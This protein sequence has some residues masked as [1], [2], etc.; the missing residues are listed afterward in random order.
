MGIKSDLRIIYWGASE[1]S[2]RI[3]ENL[4]QSG[5]NIIGVVT[6]KDRPKGRGRKL[7]SMPVKE[8]ALKF[9]IHPVEIEVIT[10]DILPQLIPLKPQLGVIMGFGILPRNL[11]EFPD[12][13]TINLHPSL[14]PQLRGAAPLRWALINGLETSGMT[15]F[16]LTE[17]VD[18][19]NIL[20]QEEF[21]IDP[22]MN[23][24]ELSE[25]VAEKGS[26]LII[27]SVER[28]ASGDYK[29]LKQDPS[30]VSKAP[31]LKKEDFFLNWSQSAVQI[32]N[33]VRAFSPEPGA[34]TIFRGDQIK[35]FKTSYTECET[36][37]EPGSISEVSA[38][39]GI[40]VNTG[41]GQITILRLQPAGKKTMEAAS[42]INGY[43]VKAGEYFK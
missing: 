3:L 21:S 1:I 30:G 43:R 4:I 42:F 29:L 22:Q 2:A 39:N 10:E 15:T 7:H 34:M 36:F 41:R 32:H 26:Q 19:G 20:L 38:K 33:R 24:G 25:M 28:I 13:G 11:F 31:K 37:G 23:Y 12:L 8:T 6:Y 40:V 5:M 18:A 9:G 16:F 17:R 27:K 14:L 35:V